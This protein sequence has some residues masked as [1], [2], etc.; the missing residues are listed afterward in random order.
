MVH[1]DRSIE[2]RVATC[3]YWVFEVLGVIN[4]GSWALLAL[5]FFESVDHRE[6][7]SVLFC[8]R[9]KRDSVDALVL[10]LSLLTCPADMSLGSLFTTAA[11]V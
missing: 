7:S 3:S 5:R 8:L 1:I 4:I 11:W 6:I 9:F 10:S 2:I